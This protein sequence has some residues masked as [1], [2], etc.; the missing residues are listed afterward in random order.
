MKSLIAFI[1]VMVFVFVSSVMACP[2]PCDV[3]VEGESYI[4]LSFEQGN[5]KIGGQAI[6][7]ADGQFSASGTKKALGDADSQGSVISFSVEKPNFALSF[8]KSSVNSDTSALGNCRTHLEISG[9]AGQTNW[10]QIGDEMNG[11][12]G[13]NY[14]DAAYQAEKNHS[15]SLSGG[16][17]AKGTTVLF[18]FSSPTKQISSGFTHGE[19]S[20]WIHGGNGQVNVS[21]FGVLATQSFLSDGN[22]TGLAFGTGSAE[23]SAT[24]RHFAEGMLNIESISSVELLPHG[25]KASSHVSS[26]SSTN[27]H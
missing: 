19:S 21:G 26:T 20:A 7:E 23:Y 27:S 6:G 10:A 17:D 15:G 24:G 9:F 8:S 18:S 2:P 12:M 13:G 14:T 5:D 11:A 1:A 25:I 22:R 16:A 4:G 3:K